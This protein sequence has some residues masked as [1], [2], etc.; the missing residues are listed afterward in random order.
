MNTKGSGIVYLLITALI[1][2][3]VAVFM[4]QSMKQAKTNPS[5]GNNDVQQAQEAVDQMNDR[6]NQYE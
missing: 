3:L 2:T 6:L 4:L 1:L 5:G